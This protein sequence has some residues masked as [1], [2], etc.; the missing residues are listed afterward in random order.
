MFKRLGFLIEELGLDAPGLVGKCLERRS[1]GIN[2]LDPSV[3][4]KGIA[5]RW[6]LRVN[7]DLSAFAA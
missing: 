2:A 1:S 6:G 7:V 5:S 3:E 4:A